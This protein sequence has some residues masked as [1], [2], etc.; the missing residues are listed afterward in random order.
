MASN[1]ALRCA[2]CAAALPRFATTV[3]YT[4]TTWELHKKPREKPQKGYHVCM[5]LTWY[6]PYH[7]H[8]RF[9]V[10]N[11]SALNFSFFWILHITTRFLNPVIYERSVSCTNYFHCNVKTKKKLKITCR[12]YVSSCE[13]VLCYCVITTSTLLWF[14]V[15]CLS[16]LNDIKDFICLVSVAYFCALKCLMYISCIVS[17]QQFSYF[18][19][20][21]VYIVRAMNPNLRLFR[22]ID[23]T[24]FIMSMSFCV[25]SYC[26]SKGNIE[27]IFCE[28]HISFYCPPSLPTH[29]LTNQNKCKYTRDPA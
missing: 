6:S 8:S 7:R 12:A 11:C 3:S 23:W 4:A 19:Q 21:V 13:T 22:T 25:F 16:L 18:T 2:Y 9:D 14:H 20:V 17:A 28:F 10:Q 26:N 1:L 15:L 29:K 27:K 5:M 24:Y